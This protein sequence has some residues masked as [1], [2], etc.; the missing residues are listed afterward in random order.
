MY[1]VNITLM[2]LLGLLSMFTFI[3][4][5]PSQKN[6]V[7]LPSSFYKGHVNWTGWKETLKVKYVSEK[8]SQWF[9]KVNIWGCQASAKSHNSF[10]LIFTQLSE[11]LLPK[12]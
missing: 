10:S 11:N 5:N 2:L 3:Y 9:L 6:I 8:V 4:Q 7:M 12:E 1:N